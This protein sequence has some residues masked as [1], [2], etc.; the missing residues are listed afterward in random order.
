MGSWDPATLSSRIQ[1][2]KVSA[3]LVSVVLRPI[4]LWFPMAESF[5]NVAREFCGVPYE[6]RTAFPEAGKRPLLISHSPKL[7]YMVIS[8]PVPG[9]G[10]GLPS[11]Q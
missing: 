10:D 6:P 8:E 3:L 11:D 2:L 7:D 9:K 4:P 5:C 1:V